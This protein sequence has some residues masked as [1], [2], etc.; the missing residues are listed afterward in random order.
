MAL[1][2][3]IKE[4]GFSLSLLHFEVQ[5][6]STGTA[7]VKCQNL[8]GLEQVKFRGVSWKNEQEAK[9]QMPMQVLKSVEFLGSRVA[10]TTQ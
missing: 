4:N 5:L 9:G 10:G 8:V 6:A 3:S 7:Q 1:G 2:R